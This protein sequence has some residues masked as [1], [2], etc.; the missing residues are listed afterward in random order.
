MLSYIHLHNQLTLYHVP[1]LHP[2]R[3]QILRTIDLEHLLVPYR[4]LTFLGR[5]QAGGR[6]APQGGGIR[7]STSQHWQ[8][9]SSK[10]ASSG[11]ASQ[12]CGLTEFVYQARSKSYI[13]IVV[14][15]TVGQGG[16]AAASLES[17]HAYK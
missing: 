9:A 6:Q 13:E 2:W 1:C 16:S 12:W 5:E 15:L 11:E 7:D 8:L 4:P 17:I 10:H 3:S 14:S